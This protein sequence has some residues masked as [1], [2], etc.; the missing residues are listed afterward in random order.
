MVFF[1]TARGPAIGGGKLNKPV[2]GIEINGLPYCTW[3]QF[4]AIRWALQQSHQMGRTP[5]VI[6]C[7][8][9]GDEVAA[10][11]RERAE[12]T[13]PNTRQVRSNNRGRGR[14]MENTTPNTQRLR[15][16]NRGKKEGGREQEE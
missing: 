11:N 7:G 8:I 12:A 3:E 16:D 13:T 10:Q 4:Q 1:C 9:H 6:Y 2:V 14:A 15:S 5:A